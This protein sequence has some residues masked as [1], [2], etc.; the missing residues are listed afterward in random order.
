MESSMKCHTTPNTLQINSSKRIGQVIIFVEGAK[1]ESDL[2]Y[3]IFHKLLNYEVIQKPTF[4]DHFMMRAFRSSNFPSSCVYVFNLSSSNIRAVTYD[5]EF[6]DQIYQKLSNNYHINLKNQPVYYL[7]DRDPKSNP[8][9]RFERLFNVLDSAQGTSN[10]YENGLLLPSYPC[11]E[12][13]HISNFSPLEFLPTK[14]HP[15]A[16]VKSNKFTTSKIS[17]ASL[18]HAAYIMHQRLKDCEITDYEPN[19]FS[20]TNHQI[21]HSEEN[22]YNQHGSYKLLSLVSI[23]LLDLGIIEEVS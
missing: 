10:N 1:T 21:Y 16:H 18:L 13:Y 20:N 6:R 3:H 5:E 7:W 15:K 9:I 4:K 8:G 14:E 23:I 19:N 17:C 22:W 2:I 11:I 12:T